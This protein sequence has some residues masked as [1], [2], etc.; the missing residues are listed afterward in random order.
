MN[1]EVIPYVLKTTFKYLYIMSQW[2]LGEQEIPETVLLQ[3]FIEYI[4][5]P[6]LDLF[7]CFDLILII[8]IN[9]KYLY[10]F[11]P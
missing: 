8:I 5:F 7:Q 2:F 4:Y 6:K 10:Y 9:L 11:F 3:C 1:T